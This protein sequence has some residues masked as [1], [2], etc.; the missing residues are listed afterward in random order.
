MSDAAQNDQPVVS[1]EKLYVKDLSLEIPNA[2][3]IFLE[4]EAPNVDVQLH[5]SS[6]KVDE[7]VVQTELTRIR[8]RAG[9][10]RTDQRQAVPQHVDRGT[11]GPERQP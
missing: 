8:K 4:R 3:Q 2:P 10:N 7:G 5:H 9:G 6:T 1:I 11:G